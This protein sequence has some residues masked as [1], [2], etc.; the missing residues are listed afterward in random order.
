MDEPPGVEAEVGA[1]PTHHTALSW[2]E[3][4]SV[5]VTRNDWGQMRKV[6]LSHGDVDCVA[7]VGIQRGPGLSQL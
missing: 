6:K 2:P 7:V 4:S 3:H 5:G 1:V